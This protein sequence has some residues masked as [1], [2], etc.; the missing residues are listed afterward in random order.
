MSVNE[1]WDE[2]DKRPV[3]VTMDNPLPVVVIG[4][5]SGGGIPDG[6]ITTSKLADGAVTAAKLSADILEKLAEIADIRGLLWEEACAMGVIRK[7]IIRESSY[8]SD[9]LSQITRLHEGENYGTAMAYDGKDH[10]YVG[11]NLTPAV[12]VKINIHTLQREGSLTLPSGTLQDETRINALMCLPGDILIHGSFTNPY[13][14]TRIDTKTLKI[15]DVLEGK[16][17]AITDKQ[18]RALVYDGKYLYVGCDTGPGKIVKIDPHGKTMERIGS[19]V[20]SPGDDR[21]YGMTLCGGYLYAACGTSPARLVKIDPDRMA[22]IKTLVFDTG[23]DQGRAI[24]TD[25]QYLYMGIAPVPGDAATPTSAGVK[26]AKVDPTT[27]Q[28]LSVYTAELGESNC[29]SLI[30]TDEYVY[31]G[32]WISPTTI[33]KIKKDDMTRVGALGLAVGFPSVLTL[34]GSHFYTPC[35]MMPARVIRFLEF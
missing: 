10:I 29:Y 3:K 7:Q 16:D 31:V 21:I 19:L 23:E 35:D 15:I 25:G 8:R 20:L 17:E 30:C 13:M 11:L 14:L 22:D 27:M 6:S 24:K 33:I 18:V 1:V 28:K 26:V 32:A 12:I 2:S 9:Q 34:I 4:G 5:G